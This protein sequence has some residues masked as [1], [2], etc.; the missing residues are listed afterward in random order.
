MELALRSEHFLVEI[1]GIRARV[2]VCI[3]G[4]W[5]LRW[6]RETSLSWN[7]CWLVDPSRLKG[8]SFP[9]PQDERRCY[10]SDASA[11]HGYAGGLARQNVELQDELAQSR[12]QVA[13]ELAALR[14]E[15]RGAPLRRRRR[16]PAWT[17][18]CWRSQA[19]SQGRRT[20]GETAAL[21]SRGTLAQRYHVCRS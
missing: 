14:Q 5:S 15:V 2:E 21:C 12:Q 20:R 11:V 4:W 10:E 17:R 19:T 16:E 18:V 13:I 3:G 9:T 7:P 1:R 8:T 6:R